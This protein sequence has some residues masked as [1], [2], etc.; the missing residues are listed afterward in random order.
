MEV[1]M[2][3]ALVI[4]IILLFL[5]VGFQPAL[6]NEVSDV[7]E[8]CLECQPVNRIDL[9]KVKLLLIRVEAITNVILSKYGHIPEVA[10]KCK[11]ASDKISI[12]KDMNEELIHNSP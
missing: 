7:D 2:K 8:D 12:L 10:E 11:V 4:C 5:G 3:K 9:L 1:N 6:A